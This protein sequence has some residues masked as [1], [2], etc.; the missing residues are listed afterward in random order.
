MKL[1]GGKS[2][3]KGYDDTTYLDIDFVPIDREGLW[4]V[5]SGSLDQRCAA[6]YVYNE[7]GYEAGIYS[8]DE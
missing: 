4:Q 2:G 7:S 3:K 5:P 6:M 1:E 8:L